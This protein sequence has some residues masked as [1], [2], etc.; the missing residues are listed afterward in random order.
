M[1]FKKIV[2]LRGIVCLQRMVSSEVVLYLKGDDYLKVIMYL[3]EVVK[4]KGVVY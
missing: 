3:K 1:C 2:Y 4:F